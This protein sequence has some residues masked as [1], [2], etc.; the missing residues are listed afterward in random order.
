MQQVQY[1]ET[2]H[3]RITNAFLDNPET[4]LRHLR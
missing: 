1:K 2:D 4:Y 3:Y